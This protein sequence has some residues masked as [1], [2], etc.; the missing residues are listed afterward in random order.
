MIIPEGFETFPENLKVLPESFKD[1]PEGLYVFAYRFLFPLY[2]LKVFVSV[3]RVF[4]R[5]SA[6]LFPQKGVDPPSSL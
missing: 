4:P 2:S 6:P 1:F 3:F 5:L